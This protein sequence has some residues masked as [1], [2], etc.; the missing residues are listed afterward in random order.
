MALLT[1]L[2]RTVPCVSRFNVLHSLSRFASWETMLPQAIISGEA[3][4]RR[5]SKRPSYFPLAVDLPKANP[6][7]RHARQHLHFHGDRTIAGLLFLLHHAHAHQGRGLAEKLLNGLTGVTGLGAELFS[8]FGRK[9]LQ[10][11]GQVAA[12]DRPEKGLQGGIRGAVTYHFGFALPHVPGRQLDSGRAVGAPAGEL[13]A[14]PF[15]LGAHTRQ[16]SPAFGE[17]GDLAP[18]P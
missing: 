14:E 16:F 10:D 3:W 9:R 17:P 5:A 2:A 6:F 1:E 12:L 13:G 8:P 18:Q 15:V 11:I 4:L 7:G